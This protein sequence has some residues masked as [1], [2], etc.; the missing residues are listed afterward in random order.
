MATVRAL[1]L[2]FERS[3]VR[4]RTLSYALIGLGLVAAVATFG[5]YRT[6]T[7]EAERW[8]KKLSDTRRMARRALPNFAEESTAA[9]EQAGELKAANQILD[10]LALPWERMF[11][12]VESAVTNDIA[13]LGVQPD[14]KN[15]NVNVTGE[16]RDLSSLLTF[17]SRLE[18]TVGLRDVHLTN[19]E[20][21]TADPNR[22]FAFSVQAQWTQEE[23]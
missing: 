18:S 19:H 2:D 10:E 15:R 9:P 7:E 8:E 16:A 21:R 20:I 5:E 3:S 13:L 1:V 17:M 4:G 23:P 11:V 14:P 22:P 12:D 6:K